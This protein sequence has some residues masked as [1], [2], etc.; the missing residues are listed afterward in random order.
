VILTDGEA[1]YLVPVVGW[2]WERHLWKS[3][4]D[5][6][7]GVDIDEPTGEPVIINEEGTGVA[8]VS[9][10]LSCMSGKFQNAGILRPG[11]T[12]GDEDDRG[13]EEVAPKE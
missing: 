9:D 6:V 12:M 11:K 5:G 8:A 10:V 3:A 13:W 1:T 7:E 4:E 2:A